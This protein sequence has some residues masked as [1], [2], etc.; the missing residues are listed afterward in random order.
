MESDQ[1]RQD[2]SYIHLF[3]GLCGGRVRLR[4]DQGPNGVIVR[5]YTLW[6]E[7]AGRVRTLGGGQDP[8]LLQEL[9]P[10]RLP[11]PQDRLHRYCQLHYR[12]LSFFFFLTKEMSTVINFG[13]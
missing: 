12:Y 11:P 2:A 6:E 5:V 10:D 3:A 1:L 8:P 7:E 13:H 4:E 9:L